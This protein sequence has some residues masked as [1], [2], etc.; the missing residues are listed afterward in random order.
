M[1]PYGGAIMRVKKSLI[2][3]T[4]ALF[5]VVVFV[6]VD[7]FDRITEKKKSDSLR[8]SE[9][10]AYL[11]ATNV[12]FRYIYQE[13]VVGTLGSYYP[14]LKI[15]D[16]MF[17]WQELPDHDSFLEFSDFYNLSIPEVNWNI[18]SIFVS[19]GRKIE[20]LRSQKSHLDPEG[21]NFKAIV[22][23]SQEYIENTFFIYSVDRKEQEGYMFVQS[24]LESPC[25]IMEDESEIYID[26]DFRFY[27]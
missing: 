26:M 5:L 22:T 12:S 15:N 11:A 2:I 18:E 14:Y 17:W 7:H 21:R 6:I 20:K 8:D 23:F 19:Y 1:V 25:F 10:S 13:E 27:K 9:I 24:F 16:K 3:V 4:L